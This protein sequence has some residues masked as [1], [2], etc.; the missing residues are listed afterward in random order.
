VFYR[1]ALGRFNEVTDGNRKIST[2]HR[3]AALFITFE[4]PN[5]MRIMRD[6]VCRDILFNEEL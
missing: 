1:K 6:E 2:R 3:H 5:W 4:E